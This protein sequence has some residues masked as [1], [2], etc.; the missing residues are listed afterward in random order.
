MIHGVGGILKKVNCVLKR[1]NGLI[2]L[3]NL[4]SG[5][6]LQVAVSFVEELAKLEKL[7][8]NLSLIVSS[9][10]DLN[11]KEIK[12][13]LSNFFKYEVI[14]THG[15]LTLLSAL[16]SK[17]KGY[18]VIF[19]L[20]G[21]LYLFPVKPLSI[22]GFAQPWI[23]YPKNEIYL[24]LS[25]FQKIK[26]KLKFLL[27]TIFFKLSDKLIVELGH[28]KAGLVELGID[29]SDISIVHN[30]INSIYL[31]P[32]CWRF[33]DF[34]TFNSMLNI[35]LISRDYPHKNID[36]LPKVK[37]A[38]KSRHNI[39]ADFYVT[40]TAKEFANKSDFFRENI[41]NVG[42]LS[43]TECPDFYR[44]MDAIIFPSF[45]EC[46]SATPLEAMFMGKPLFASDR[47]FVRD[48]CGDYAYYFD[49]ESPDDIANVIADYCKKNKSI[50][51][52]KAHN[53]SKYVLAE[54]NPTK[55]AISYL[56]L[57]QFGIK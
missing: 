15:L 5:G 53:A 11:L 45:L 26:T 55:R 6:A 18:D 57:M 13:D 49:P 43:V 46:F 27:Q 23:I 50:N 56:N 8:I 12:C 41:K 1:N 3:S 51:L 52:Q 10:V 21:P 36:I 22:V 14:D 2:N 19:T 28:V 4:H 35:G 34:K 31:K 30:S 29:Y 40:L 16:R 37:L 38:L 33:S 20:F 32:E 9:E 25:Y 17:L 44:Q 54:F 7:P 48:V 47:G 42:E 24:R 39:E